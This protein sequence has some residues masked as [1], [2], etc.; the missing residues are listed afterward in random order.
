MVL[1][2]CGVEQKDLSFYDALKELGEV[3]VYPRT[4]REDTV[5]RIGNA[6]AI[7][8]NK[9]LIDKYVLDACPTVKFVGVNATGYNVVDIKEAAA[10]GVTVCNVPA[11]S[12]DS[13]AQ[14]TFAL[15]L[16]LCSQVGLH[17]ASVKGGGWAS[18][19]DFCYALVPLKELSGKTFGIIGYG[20]IGQRVAKIAQALNMRVIFYNRTPK[21][22]GLPLDEVLKN[23]DIVSLHCALS[24][25][26]AKLINKETIAKMKDGALLI[27]TARGGLIDEQA[28]ADA[29]ASGKLAGAAVDVLSS[30]PPSHNNPLLSAKNC[31]ITP[32]IAWMS[33]EARKRLLDITVQNLKSYIVGKPQNV[34][35]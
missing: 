32:H 25:D 31:I 12:T 26:N 7:F 20:T 24:A 14:M 22:G 23:S 28:L 35:K 19:P 21:E 29:L 9:V 4:Q 27:N 18:C 11:Y 2:A 3:A 30:E 13:V 33:F 10:R 17:N 34:I 15:L 6:E 16:E 1:D 8:T 5:D